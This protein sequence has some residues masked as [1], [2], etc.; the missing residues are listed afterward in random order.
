[1]REVEGS[2]TG[3]TNTH[4]LKISEENLPTLYNKEMDRY[5]SLLG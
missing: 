4:G 1:M 5:S 2:I 3:W